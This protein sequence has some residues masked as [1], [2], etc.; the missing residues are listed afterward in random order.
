ME[1]ID[2][3]VHTDVSVIRNSN[4]EDKPSLLSFNWDICCSSEFAASQ[5]DATTFFL[6]VRYE[7]SRGEMFGL[8]Y[9]AKKIRFVKSY[10]GEDIWDNMEMLPLPEGTCFEIDCSNYEAIK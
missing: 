8:P 2:G 1:V 10:D 6:V 7:P 3:P 9:G 5:A 4:G